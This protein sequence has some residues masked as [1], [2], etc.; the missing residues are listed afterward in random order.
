[1]RLR[2]KRWL[3]AGIDDDTWD[4]AAKRATHNGMG[5]TFL[6]DFANGLSEEAC[7]RI[8]HGGAA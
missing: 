3:V 4:D 8:A 1:M 7:D 6:V 2:C 5:G